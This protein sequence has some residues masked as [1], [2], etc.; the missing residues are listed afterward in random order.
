LVFILGIINFRKV[1]MM[2]KQ[3]PALL[4]AALM[5]GITAMAMLVVSF[6][7]LFNHN[8]VTVSN[9]PSNI[10]LVSASSGNEQAQIVQLQNRINEYQQREAQYQQLL[11]R[12]QSQLQQAQAQLDQASQ[13]VQQFQSFIAALQN[14]G[15]IRI[16]NDGSVIITAQ[17]LQ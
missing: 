11:Q 12:D 7:A 17:P 4:A 8:G 1:T 3:I 9:S 6:S 15:L 2:K 14:R 10:A 5:T 16:R 13:Q